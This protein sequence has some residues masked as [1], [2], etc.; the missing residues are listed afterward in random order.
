M[1]GKGEYMRKWTIRITVCIIIGLST[2]WFWYAEFTKPPAK[3]PAVSK[4]DKP[5]KIYTKIIDGRWAE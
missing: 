1:I 2:G 4:K 5:I 3:P